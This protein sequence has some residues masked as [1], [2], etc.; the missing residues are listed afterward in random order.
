MLSRQR[1]ARYRADVDAAAAQASEFVNAYIETMMAEMPRATVAEIR[2][3][4]IEAIGD[5]MYAFGDQAAEAACE[6]FDELALDAGAKE[7]AAIYDDLVDTAKVEEKVRYLARKL[8]AGD[9]EGFGRSV[10]DVTAYYVKR[11]AMENMVRNCHAQHVR[12]ARVTTGLEACSFC[13]MLSSRGFVYH[14]EATA[15]GLHGYHEHCNCVAVPGFADVGEDEQIEGYK[16][17]GM[18]DRFRM[19]AEAVGVDGARALDPEYR[20]KVLKEVETRDWKWLYG[21]QPCNISEENG[22]KPLPKERKVAEAL[23]SCGFETLFLKEVNKTGIKTADAELNR[24]IWE[25]KI[26]EGWSKADAGSEEGEHTVRKQF[27][28]ALGKGTKKLLLANDENKAP[29]ESLVNLAERVLSSGDY[30]FDEVLVVD[31]EKK[32]IRRLTR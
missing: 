28:K 2:Q 25:F 8:V 24:E 7:G 21:G 1:L 26:P 32:K 16:P 30:D 19:C 14:S 10:R 5:A 15:L 4:A 22:A 11:S 6:L 13:F 18:R 12:Y 31:S 17:R 3:A 29:F 20:K 23:A 27:Y 9:R